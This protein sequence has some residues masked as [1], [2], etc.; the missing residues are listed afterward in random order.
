[1]KTQPEIQTTSLISHNPLRRSYWRK[2]G[3]G[4]LMISLAIHSIII[5]AGLVWVFNVIPE[6]QRAD[7]SF[8]PKSVGRSPISEQ[9]AEK[10]HAKLASPS[11]NR[12]I[13]L[14]AA[15]VINLPDPEMTAMSVLSGTSI[16]GLAPAKIG[17]NAFKALGPNSNQGLSPNT[18][19]KSG[20]SNLFGESKANANALLGRLYDLK[21]TRSRKPI[22]FD[23]DQA[24]EVVQEFVKSGWKDRMLAA[25]HDVVS[26]HGEPTKKR[27]VSL[28]WWWR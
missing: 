14:G 6:P 26:R 18:L 11:L 21:Q 13:A 3:G 28:R 4:S 2:I 7:V 17:N 20:A 24:A 19:N 25:N 23:Q 22:A 5:I 9:N 27:H 16:D 12:T 8:V 15:T 10:S 1:M